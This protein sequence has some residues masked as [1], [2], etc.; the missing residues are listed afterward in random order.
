MPISYFQPETKA[1]LLAKL[2]YES[3]DILLQF[4]NLVTTTEETLRNSE[5]SMDQL[6]LFFETMGL[7]KITSNAKYTKNVIVLLR[8]ITYENCWS[9]FSYKLL[10]ILIEKF[11]INEPVVRVLEEYRTAFK[12]YCLCQAYEVPID[13]IMQS[14]SLG[15]QLCVKMDE[16]F[17]ISLKNVNLIQDRIAS[18]LNLEVLVLADLNKGSIELTFRF[19]ENADAIFP[20]SEER[21]LG[22]ALIGVKW[23]QS[24][25]YTLISEE[26]PEFR[27]F[28]LPR[29][30]K[31]HH[32]FIQGN[33]LS[34][35]EPCIKIYGV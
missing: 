16:I 27:P 8:K 12:K 3:D 5:I 23:L 32:K 34:N 9:F 33:S 20:V 10:E 17:S 26:I 1:R 6:L 21:K 31:L 25:Q 13:A 35:N 18:I 7:E 24:D 11:C 22:L 30:V 2:E 28:F 4:T 15:H 14:S 19:F 29:R